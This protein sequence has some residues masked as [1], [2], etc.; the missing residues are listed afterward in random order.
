MPKGLWHQGVAV[1]LVPWCTVPEGQEHVW[2]YRVCSFI[3]LLMD[4][5]LRDLLRYFLKSKV[6]PLICHMTNKKAQVWWACLEDGEMP[7]VFGSEL[8][9]NSPYHSKDCQIWEGLRWRE[10]SLAEANY[11]VLYTYTICSYDEVATVPFKVCLAHWGTNHGRG[12]I[13]IPRVLEQSH[14]FIDK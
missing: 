12:I 5:L 13:E 7:I 3:Y 11:S 1:I 9:N 2:K 6:V 4:L 14:V 8:L 10:A